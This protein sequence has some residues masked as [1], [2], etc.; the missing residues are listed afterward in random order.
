MT[1]NPTDSG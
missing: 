1:D